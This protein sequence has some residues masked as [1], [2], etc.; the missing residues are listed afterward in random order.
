LDDGELR[1]LRLMGNQAA[2]AI[3]RARLHQAELQALGLERE[4]ALGREIQLSLLPEAVP[5]LPGWEFATYYEA[6]RQVG[7]DFYDFFSLAGEGRLPDERAGAPPRP[8][9]QLGMVVA[10]VA[11]KG[12]PAALFMALSR[13]LIRANALNGRSPAAALV[14]VNELLLQDSRANMFLS[15][16]YAVLD[17]QSGRLAFAN[18]GHNPPLWLQAESGRVRELD[19]PGTVLGAFGQTWLE[20][21]EVDIAPG[22]YLV[23]YTDGITEAVDDERNFFE[24]GRLHS[25][26]TANNGNSA[27]EVL[28]AIVDAVRAFAGDEP[29]SDDLTVCVVRRLPG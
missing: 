5:A 11:G 28:G 1:L 15:A 20:D 22:D 8:G 12:V 14:R 16:F 4:M 6:A 25:V 23:L 3:D 2:M 26:V 18:A 19:A 10:D 21:G 9:G 29:Q 17:R 13:T 27:Q 7:G 24:E